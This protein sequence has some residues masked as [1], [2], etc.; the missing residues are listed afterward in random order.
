MYSM[1]R[2][3]QSATARL[4][5]DLQS[6][7]SRVN[8]YRFCQLLEQCSPQSPPIGSSSKIGDDP[9]RFRPHPGMGFPAGEFKRLT[10]PEEAG[11]VPAAHVTFMGLYGVESPLPTA[12]VDDIT[13]RREGH[14][15]VSDF[16]DIFNHRLVTQFYRIWRKYSWPASFLP[17]GKDKTSQY[18]LSLAGL[19]LRGCAENIA[20]PVS[21]FLAL[22]GVMR[23]PTRTR[24]GIMTIVQL[25][26]PDTRAEII[27]H[28]PVRVALKAPLRMSVSTPVSLQNRPVM[29]QHAIDVNHQVHLRLTTDNPEEAQNWLPGE[30]LHQ[31][32]LVLLQVYL[33]AKLD[34]RLTLTLAREL[35]PDASLSCHAVGNRVLLGR[36]AVMRQSGTLPGP[37]EITIN[38]GRY[39]RLRE[40]ENR[41]EADEVGNYRD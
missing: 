20:T 13:Q 14:E 30:T 33:G 1:E 27:A 34:V 4:T 22:S 26:A 24:E 9:V 19:G 7:I 32:F 29:G 40:Q 21:R 25:L 16:L 41:R 6:D 17:G 12:Y 10:L 11:E 2:E 5:T 37:K 3:P 23:L 15:A 18:L 28:D 35:L 31:D 38:L 39:Q 8:F 36:T